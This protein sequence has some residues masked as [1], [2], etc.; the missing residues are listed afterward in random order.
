MEI[1]VIT[2]AGKSYHQ[3]IYWNWKQFK[4][5]ERK[6]KCIW[7]HGHMN[8]V[9]ISAKTMLVSFQLSKMH[10]FW[11][12]PG[13]QVKEWWRGE[14]W[15][16]FALVQAE[17]PSHTPHQM[18]CISWLGLFNVTRPASSFSSDHSCCC[19]LCWFIS[20]AFEHH[21]AMIS[22]QTE[23]NVSCRVCFSDFSQS[24]LG[25]FLYTPEGFI[26]FSVDYTAARLNSS[27]RAKP[28]LNEYKYKSIILST[29]WLCTALE[30]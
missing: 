27:S 4:S 25:S 7:A 10:P 15:K 1:I 3:N 18:I 30:N 24:Q 16:R 9:N 29:V 6:K 13:S 21:A 14:I 8:N 26:L 5:L 11:L 19:W 17:A 20:P 22:S 23:P 12:I 2:E 28:F